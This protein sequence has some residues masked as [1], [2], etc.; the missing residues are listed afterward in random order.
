MRVIDTVMFWRE[1]DILELRMNI[2]GDK[3]DKFVL[4]EC[5]RTYTGVYKGFNLE[6]Q[7]DR[8]AKWHDKIEYI[9]VENSPA[10]NDP[11]ENERW[12]R[13]Q[14]KLGW[15]DVTP[16]DVVMVCDCDEII[17]PEAIDYIKNS[18]Y[19]L[20]K[21]MMP[22]FYYKF[23]YMD[24]A[25]HYSPWGRAYR[26]F[27][28]DGNDMR[29]TDDVPKE[30]TITVHHA[31]WHFGWMGDEEFVKNKTQSFSHRE[32]DTPQIINNINIDRQ[33]AEGRDHFRPHKV[34]WSP[35]KFDSYYPEYL[36]NNKDKYSQYIIPDGNQSVRDVWPQE[37]LELQ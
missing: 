18:N 1:F 27:M 16:D 28:C 26:G 9:K 12:Q 3:V 23:N 14:M 20:Y 35:V 29:Y 34:T 30:Q 25:E 13:N 17:R 2:I 4:V 11:W 32:F 21:L 22:G 5:D 15:Q 8:Y 6:K 10:W 33:I 24:M 31:G 37:L 19:S 7:W 36:L